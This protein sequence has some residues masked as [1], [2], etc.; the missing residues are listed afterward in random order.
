MKVHK[1]RSR[2]YLE[3]KIG[4]SSKVS[5]DPS[6]PDID[7]SNVDKVRCVEGGKRVKNSSRPISGNLWESPRQRTIG[8]K[9][10][11]KSS[12]SSPLGLVYRR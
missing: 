2:E 8:G 11:K 4:I 7:D 5:C 3:K 10:K 12:K 1:S 9:R 6:S